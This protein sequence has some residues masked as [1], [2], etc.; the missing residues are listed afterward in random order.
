MRNY[1]STMRGYIFLGLFAMV[2][3]VVMGLGQMS[4]NNMD[5]NVRIDR[6]VASTEV[7]YDGDEDVEFLEPVEI[8]RVP[9]QQLMIAL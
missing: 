2:M 4:I 3:A 8:E 6:R 1:K 5:D 7:S 9:D